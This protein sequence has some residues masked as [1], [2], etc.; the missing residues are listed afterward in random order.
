MAI[1]GLANINIGL[2]N[3]SIGS[4]SLFTAFN[5]IRNNFSVLSNTASPYNTFTANSGINIE[6]NS[7]SGEVTVTNTG[8]WSI[9]P[10][11]SSIVVNQSNGAITIA[12]VGG[13]GN[14][15]GTVTSVG[16]VSTT[17]NVS[18]TTGGSII[19]SGNIVVDLQ[20]SGVT[21]GN[22]RNPSVVI[23][24]YGRVTSASNNE[25]SGT[26][27][28]VGVVPGTGIQVTGS[29]ITTSGN[30]TIVNTG[31]TRLSAG[32]GISLS[33]ANGNV[34]ISTTPVA[35][36][37]SVG[38]SSSSLTISGSPVTS[39][40]TIAVDLPTNIS[41]VGNVT[42]SKVLLLPGSESL[43]NT[44]AAN[45]QVTASHISTT[46]PWISSLASGA[47]GQLKTFMMVSDG[48][49]MVITVTNAGW[50][51]SGTGTITFNDIGDGCI[52]QYIN[53]KWYCI[54]QNG[55]TFG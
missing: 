31:V 10:A 43:A 35:A 1:S 44:A 23:D 33:G 54:G 12:S 34:T 7:A 18:T 42:A 51:T 55:V 25:V 38:V 40:G 36:V 46:G 14:G 16:V 53:N 37:T 3:E 49:D 9:T 30:I 11:D 17:M 20:A 13:G 19:N 24:A 8:V 29:P 27:T 32:S 52:L 6:A 21:P 22:Y 26:V 50:R 2:Q 15:G 45:L 47:E 39:T 48:G 5:K 4:D 28:S 41:A